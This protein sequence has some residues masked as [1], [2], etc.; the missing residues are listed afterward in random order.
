MVVYRVGQFFGLMFLLGTSVSCVNQI[1]QTQMGHEGDGAPVFIAEA[2][3]INDLLETDPD[4]GW[5]RTQWLAVAPEH[6]RLGLRFDSLG[7]V[8]VEARARDGSGGASSSWTPFVITYQDGIAH[9]ARMDFE[10]ERTQFQVRF[11]SPVESGLTFVN[12]ETMVAGES[13]NGEDDSAVSLE[14]VGQDEGALVADSITVTRSQWGARQRNCGSYH[15]PNML[16]IHHTYTPNIDSLSMAARVR[17]IQSYHIDVRGW[18]DIG[19]HFLVGQDGQVY[20]GRYENKTGAHA[21]GANRNNVGISLI[22]NFSDLTPSQSMQTAT[23]RT[24]DAMATEYGISRTRAR[25]KGHREVGSTA[26]S[27]PGEKTFQ[28]LEQLIDLSSNLSSPPVTPEPEPSEPE[29]S[30]PE[31]PATDPSDDNSSTPG[32][33][34][35]LPSD[36]W[37]FAAAEKLRDLGAFWGCEPGLF[38][39]DLPLTRA[40]AAYGIAHLVNGSYASLDGPAFSDIAGSH[41]A[42]DSVQEIAARH[43]TYGCGNGQFCPNGTV[44]RATMAV[45][46]RR[47][48][49]IAY[50]TPSQPTFY[51][52]PKSHWA[53]GSIE[54]ITREGWSTGCTGSSSMY[55]PD[56]YVT[57]AQA[58]VFLAKAFEIWAE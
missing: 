48:T 29:P 42:Y 10:S 49:G 12:I 19:Y 44:S 34:S 45:F 52:V 2:D 1:S 15:S 21:G 38:C 17:Q 27:C 4:T 54:G 3:T 25:I 16:T 22:G 50:E 6:N 30:E 43:I 13:E 5:S 31:P 33:Y 41:W 40:N 9:N 20:Q 36:H 51:D 47:A 24:I 26:T 56:D 28:I 32:S 53:Y 57:R 7:A 55:C 58:V 35:D 11:L 14:E 37:A 46:L 23:A 39:P 18:C 8:I